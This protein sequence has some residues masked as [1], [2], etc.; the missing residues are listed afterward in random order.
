MSRPT[1]ANRTAP[2]T[3]SVGEVFAAFLRLG[4]TSFGGPARRW[5]SRRSG[6]ESVNLDDV[7]SLPWRHAR[8]RRAPHCH[9]RP[10]AG[11]GAA[12]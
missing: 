2:P 8:D 7:P 5:R 9:A 1:A 11:R 10:R 12:E 4:L 3:G 6:G